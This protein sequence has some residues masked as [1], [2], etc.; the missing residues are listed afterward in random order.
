MP[1]AG[2]LTAQLACWQYYSNSTVNTWFKCVQQTTFTKWRCDL[3]VALR[4][5]TLVTRGSNPTLYHIF[6]FI[7]HSV[8]PVRIRLGLGLGL[9][10]LGLGIVLV[11]L[12]YDAI[13]L[14]AG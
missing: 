9:V 11:Y 3:M 8:Y 13:V 10:F 5:A 7:F 12:A 4:L 14:P 6:W 1:A 2:R